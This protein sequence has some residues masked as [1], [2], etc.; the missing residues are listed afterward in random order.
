[1]KQVT[2]D[3]LVPGMVISE[4]VLDYNNN[5]IV[6]AGVILTEPVISRLSA[7]SIFSVNIEDTTMQ[8]LFTKTNMNNTT[9]SKDDY[10]NLIS[11][12]QQ[13][14]SR[15]VYKLRDN[16]LQAV[17]KHVA[18]NINDITESAYQ[19][20]ASDAYSGLNIFEMLLYTQWHEDSIFSHSLNVSLIAHTLADWLNWN[21]SDKKLAI[22]CGLFHDIGKLLVPAGILE[23]PDRLTIA[24]FDIIKTHTTEGYHLLN[25]FD[26]NPHIKAAALMHHEK[27]D[28]KGYPYGVSR[29][30]IDPFAKLIT[31]SDI[32]EAMTSTRVYRDAMCPFDVIN[33][34]EKEGIEKYEPEYIMTF[35]ENAANAYMNHKV[36]LSNGMEGTVV[37][38]NHCNFSKPTVQLNNE[39]W[40]LSKNSNIFI[41]TIL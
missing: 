15:V 17:N 32:Y 28:G 39:F 23:K 8:E 25:H 35:L 37:F 24:E 30:D 9:F 18:P 2:L 16:C 11:L 5:C 6:P 20:V 4:D 3:Q 12:F 13:D 41:E 40:D 31:I 34:F 33:N 10:A 1:M 27:C 22:S 7:Y 14:W 19:L 26:I 29:E 36:S 38:I 21:E